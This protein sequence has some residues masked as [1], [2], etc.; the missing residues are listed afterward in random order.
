LRRLQQVVEGAGEVG[1]VDGGQDALGERVAGLEG[2]VVMDGAIHGG[3]ELAEHTADLPDEGGHN[4]HDEQRHQQD[5]A[6]EGQADGDAAFHAAP[7]KLV[8]HHVE[9]DRQH[10]A[11][12][13]QQQGGINLGDEQ[14][15]DDERYGHQ[16][17]NQDALGELFSAHTVLLTPCDS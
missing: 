9:R 11:G 7:A 5:H 4:Q 8:N 2:R 6:A 16:P 12:E 15:G 14:E 10:P 1:G 17:D 3:G 13:G